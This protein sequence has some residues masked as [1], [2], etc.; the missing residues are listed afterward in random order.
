MCLIILAWFYSV[1]CVFLCNFVCN[2][3]IGETPQHRAL[4]LVILPETHQM[5]LPETHLQNIFQ[6]IFKTIFTY[7]VKDRN[8]LFVIKH[9]QPI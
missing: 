9:W 7:K 3:T 4:P 6:N 2:K 8:N 5:I 1:C